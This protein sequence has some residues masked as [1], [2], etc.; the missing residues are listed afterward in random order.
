MAPSTLATRL[1]P[2]G[3]VLAFLQIA[4]LIVAIM[5]SHWKTWEDSGNENWQ[6]L[7]DVCVRPSG[8]QG[9]ACTPLGDWQLAAGGC[10][11]DDVQ[12]GAN[13]LIGLTIAAAGIQFICLVMLCVGGLLCGLQ[14]QSS[15]CALVCL[16]PGA[17]SVAF[18]VGAAVATSTELNCPSVP[19]GSSIGYAAILMY[20][21]A[22]FGALSIGVHLIRGLVGCC[23]RPMGLIDLEPITGGGGYQYAD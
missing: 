21:A 19:T 5:D 13:V 6:G 1:L 11:T 14:S 18:N 9:F 12:K 8:S 16:V 3:M 20:T 7:W 4:L 15:V 23:G 17:V 10:S 22:G 2:L